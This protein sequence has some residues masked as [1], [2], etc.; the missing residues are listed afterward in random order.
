MKEMKAKGGLELAG[1]QIIEIYFLNFL[2][3]ADPYIP[4][5]D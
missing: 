3:V 4:I 1:T 5:L 2:L